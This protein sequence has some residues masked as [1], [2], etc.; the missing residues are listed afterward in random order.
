MVRRSPWST[1]RCR[2]IH[3]RSS[4]SSCRRNMEM[5]PAPPHHRLNRRE[6]ERAGPC[7]P[8][9]PDGGQIPRD[10]DQDSARAMASLVPARCDRT[11]RPSI[12]EAKRAEVPAQAAPPSAQAAPKRP[13]VR[14]VLHRSGSSTSIVGVAIVFWR[15]GGNLWN[16]RFCRTR[17]IPRPPSNVSQNCVSPCHKAK[18]GE[19]LTPKTAL[20]APSTSED[21]QYQH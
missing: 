20:A 19:F 12:W 18:R 9:H 3:R 17:A 21:C 16:R 11:F 7:V 10:R 4:N 5:S 14:R 2:E 1:V 13:A 8:G 15:G 6:E